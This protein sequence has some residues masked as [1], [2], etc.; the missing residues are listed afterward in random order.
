MSTAKDETAIR[1]GE[2]AELRTLV[3]MR[4][5]LL[6]SQ[7]ADRHATQMAQID[8]RVAAKFQEDRSR[9][10]ELKTEL[11]RVVTRA[12]RAAKVVLA[13]YPDV[14]EMRTHMFSR[15]WINQPDQ[16]KDKLR[17]AMVAMVTAATESAKLRVAKLE[18][19]LLSE[20]ALSAIK[21]DQAKEFVRTI[22]DIEELMPADRLNEIEARF[23]ADRLANEAA[24][25][26]G[27][28]QVP[29]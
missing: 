4:V 25:R 6:R 24:D 17:K 27:A 26:G 8:G 10:E 19:E 15:P 18:A 23:D 16:G 21:T 2:R 29:Q 11:D 13:K 5:K 14:A 28:Q 3:R 9:I 22:P 7:I 20:L 12:N 1:P